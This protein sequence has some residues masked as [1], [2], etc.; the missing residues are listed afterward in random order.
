MKKEKLFKVTYRWHT[1]NTHDTQIVDAETLEK[2]KKS[3]WFVILS[4][5]EY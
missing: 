3:H 2:M 5:E 4:I 1:G